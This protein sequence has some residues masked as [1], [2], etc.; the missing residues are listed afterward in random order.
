M[1]G[2]SL[3]FGWLAGDAHALGSVDDV[4]EALTA[5]GVESV[6]LRAVKPNTPP[7]DVARA[8]ASLRRHGLG[9]TIHAT[10]ASAETAVADL[11]APLAD[12]FRENGQARVVITIH[13]VAGD[14]AAMLTALADHIDAHG[15]PAVIALENNRLLPD[16]TEGD[17]TALVLDAVQAAGR[18]NVGICFDMGHYQ[19][20]VRKNHPDTPDLLP[21]KAF[22]AHVV[23]THIHALNGLKTHF[24]LD[25]HDLPL[26]RMVDALCHKYYGVY[27]IELDFPRFVGLRQ[28][29][30]ALLGSVDTLA[31]AMPH[32]ARLYDDIRRRFDDRFRQALTVFDGDAPGTRFALVQSASYLFNTNGYRWAMDLTFREAYRLA[33]TPAQAAALLAPVQLMIISHGHGDH[34]EERTVRQLAGT[35]M[36]W[37]IPDFLAEQAAA[38]GI[39][40][41]K[42][43]LAR[44]GQTMHMGPLTILPFV[45]RHFRPGGGAGLPEYGYHI[46]AKG[47]PSLVFPV[48]VRD[49]ALDGLPALPEADYC[50]ANVWL[51]DKTALNADHTEMSQALARFMLRFC[52]KNLLLTHLYE[53][54]RA[55]NAMWRD[56]HAAIV[57][58]AIRALSPATRVLVPHSGEIIALD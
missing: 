5:R 48:D 13:P 6:E 10:V 31:A 57:A 56:T 50:F 47:A 15:L 49:F 4:L 12:F 42:M 58:D 43:H 27:N 35:A 32:C 25:S 46:S 38:W 18:K 39:S 24:P 55:D 23:H 7:A 41:E 40:P 3:P 22:F 34:F 14:N 28:P 17:S 29:L 2:V 44:D 37:V 8:A 53:N 26:G 11:F 30:P 45:S 9:V 21:G 33:Q 16:H 52:T 1:I 36:H 54:G 19:Y 51:G 20:F